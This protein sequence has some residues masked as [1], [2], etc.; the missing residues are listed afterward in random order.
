GTSALAGKAVNKNRERK[1]NFKAAPARN[2]PGES[3]ALTSRHRIFYNLVQSNF[4][5]LVCK[6]QGEFQGKKW[7]LKS[8]SPLLAVKNLLFTVS[9][10]NRRGVTRVTPYCP[11]CG[12]CCAWP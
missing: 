3:K 9:L 5:P 11:C 12:A 10:K 7:H 1:K 6:G 8:V 4:L 2:L